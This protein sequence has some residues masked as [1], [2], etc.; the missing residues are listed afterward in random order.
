MNRLSQEESCSAQLNSKHKKQ[1]DQ[2]RRYFALIFKNLLWF[3]Q[4]LPVLRGHDE[5]ENS[6][7]KGNFLE[8]IYFQSEYNEKIQRN[9]KQAFS[10]LSQTIRTEII[11]IVAAQI[12]KIILLETTCFFNNSR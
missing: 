11:E 3:G 6:K 2:N 1:I 12:I 5:T 8:L 7:K 9:F 4:K 10:Y